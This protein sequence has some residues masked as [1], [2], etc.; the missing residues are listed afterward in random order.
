MK[1]KRNKA[2]MINNQEGF[3]LVELLVAITILAIIVLPF[4][5]SFV[6]ASK[7]NSKAR[8]QLVA[9]TVAQNVME[10][11]KATSIEALEKDDNFVFDDTLKKYVVTYD[12]D[13][14]F[15]RVNGKGYNARVLFDANAYKKAEGA[16]ND[17]YNDQKVADISDMNILEDG[18][19][20]QYGEQDRTYAQAITDEIN[21]NSVTLD[22]V[23]KNMSRTVTF[24]VTSTISGNDNIATVV[25]TCQYN[26]Q[27]HTQTFKSTIYDNADITNGTLRAVYFFY[28]PLYTSIAGNIKDNIIINNNIGA[29]KEA[30]DVKFYLVK[31]MTGITNSLNETITTTDQNN[32]KVNVAVNEP[33]G[34]ETS[35]VTQVRTNI[36]WRVDKQ[37]NAY[38]AIDSQLVL[39]YTR[40]SATAVNGEEAKT[41]VD[42]KSLSGEEAKDRIYA[43]TVEVYKI[44]TVESEKYDEKNKLLTYTG[45]K[46]E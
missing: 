9:T 3:S 32:Y 35:P 44:T 18:F 14:T 38:Q 28:N 33:A 4:L 5:N 29:G 22:M 23:L 45:S 8:E 26:Y 12:G 43:V 6:T 13:Q 34:K 41:I 2:S 36:G 16:A 46:I 30:A 10:E 37:D 11:I 15:M 7:T 31:Q 24:D 1:N 21:S 20:V 27:G 40:G 19:Y 25:M 42:Y 39:A 17:L